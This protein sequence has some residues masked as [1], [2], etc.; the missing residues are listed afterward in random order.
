MMN[1]EFMHRFYRE[2]EARGVSREQAQIIH[3]RPLWFWFLRAAFDL[4]IW[5]KLP[6][7]FVDSVR[8]AWREYKRP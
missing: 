1:D 2:C 4:T 8:V 5:R 6:G 7:W 3:S